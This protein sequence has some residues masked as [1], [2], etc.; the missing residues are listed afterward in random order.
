MHFKQVIFLLAFAFTTLN[1]AAPKKTYSDT[2]FFDPDNFLGDTL[3]IKAQFMEC[4]EWGGHLEL[5]KIFLRENEFYIN[6]QK[7]SADCDSVKENNGRPRQ[8]LIEALNKKLRNK[9][10]QLVREYV[11]Q[12]IDAKF[13]QPSPMNAGYIFEIKNSNQTIKLFVYTWGTTTR[14]EYLQFIKKLFD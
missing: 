3:Y 14:N 7:F 11:H 12:L 13:R 1:C 6:Y 2:T 4:G 10:K 5:S 9:D 8:T